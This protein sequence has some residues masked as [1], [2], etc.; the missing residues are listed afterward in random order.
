MSKNGK[1]ILGILVALVLAVVIYRFN[2]Q[3]QYK[4]L[5]GETYSYTF[6]EDEKEYRDG[7]RYNII[8]FENDGVTIYEVEDIGELPDNVDIDQKGDR[9]VNRKF[10][11]PV[12][13]EKEKTVTAD[14]LK[15]IIKVKDADNIEYNGK[16]YTK[17]AN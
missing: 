9:Q 13:N 3:D 8:F 2:M 14:D 12:Y 11:N 10:L 15:E 17:E 7:Y 16:V 5:V 1:I 4:N 6:T